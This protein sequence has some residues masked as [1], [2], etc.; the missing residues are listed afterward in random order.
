MATA[1]TIRRDRAHLRKTIGD[2]RYF[3]RYDERKSYAWGPEMALWM[4]FGPFKQ[5]LWALRPTAA[6]S[7]H[8]CEGFMREAAQVRR[9]MMR[10]RK[11]P[12]RPKESAFDRERR[13]NELWND[14]EAYEKQV[15]RRARSA[16][17]S[18]VFGL[19]SLAQSYAHQL[20]L[21]QRYWVGGRPLSESVSLLEGI[22]AVA[23]WQRHNYTESWRE[24]KESNWSH[25][26]L[27]SIGLW[28]G[29]ERLPQEFLSRLGCTTYAELENDYFEAVAYMML[30][31]G[32]THSPDYQPDRWKNEDPKKAW[33]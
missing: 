30:E 25:V 7:F 29:G 19:D 27:K 6:A 14:E 8:E 28:H 12:K 26:V 21:P 1:A 15:L 11:L 4:Q 5:E 2:R 20:N 3:S 18:L 9:D 32:L 10:I 22:R 31:M 33:R 23:N 17:E 16:A 24:Y 13:L